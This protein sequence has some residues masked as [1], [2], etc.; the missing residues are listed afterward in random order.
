MHS[1][2]FQDLMDT[3]VETFGVIYT[4]AFIIVDFLITPLHENLGDDMIDFVGDIAY[5]TPIE[6]MF[7]AG[8]LFVL[9]YALVKFFVPL[10]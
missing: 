4:S 3:L 2:L 9:V 5:M 6:F 10:A 1:I 8:L 7:G